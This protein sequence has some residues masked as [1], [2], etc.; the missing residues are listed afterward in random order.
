MYGDFRFQVLCHVRF[1]NLLKLT[2]FFLIIN[3]MCFFYPCATVINI[4]AHILFHLINK[5]LLL[6]TICNF[7]NRFNFLSCLKRQM[8][9]IRR[10]SIPQDIQFR[11]RTRNEFPSKEG[12][13][14]IVVSGHVYF[15]T[16]CHMA[17]HWMSM[18]LFRLP[19]RIENSSV[20]FIWST[21]SL[22][23]NK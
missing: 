23:A 3:M 18:I 6:I 22:P 7:I 9:S 12:F 19:S 13:L 14:E 8:F 1:V 2:S 11:L 16:G 15:Y 17:N 4:V 10:E 21:K 5:S 20:G